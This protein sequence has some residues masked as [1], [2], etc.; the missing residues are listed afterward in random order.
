[1]KNG[2]YELHIWDLV[3]YL[4]QRIRIIFHTTQTY[5][6][7]MVQCKC[8]HYVL[9]ETFIWLMIKACMFTKNILMYKLKTSYRED[10]A[11]QTHNEFFFFVLNY[12]R[13]TCAFILL[14]LFLLL[15]AFGSNIYMNL[16]LPII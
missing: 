15:E 3:H 16:R 12:L 9:C 11:K 6:I 8:M 5:I 4:N 10:I 2:R 7:E 1:M 14:V 13:F